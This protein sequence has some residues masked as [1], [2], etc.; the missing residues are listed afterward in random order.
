MN[1]NIWKRFRAGSPQEFPHV[2]AEN[3]AILGASGDP[4]TMPPAPTHTRSR[5][6]A[7]ASGVLML[8]ALASCGGH[9]Y[10][11][12]PDV[13]GVTKASLDSGLLDEVAVLPQP[14]V[15]VDR[16]AADFGATVK[17]GS[18]S[19]CVRFLP[20]TGE[21]PAHLASRLMGDSRVVVAEQNAIIETAEARQE[22]YASDDGNGSLESTVEQ[23]ALEAIGLSA[24]HDVSSGRGIRVAIID[25]GID[26]THPLF[27]GRIVGG[28]DYVTYDYDPTDVADGIDSDGDGQIDEAWG[29]GTHVAG[30]VAI[31]AP[32]AQ[33][34][35]ARVLDSDGR[36]DVAAV[37][38]GLRW[39]IDHGARVINMSLGMLHPSL[40][41]ETLL[42][43][44]Q[45]NGV[46][47]VCSAG[48]WGAE[49]PQEYPAVS[50]NVIAVAATDAYA[51]PAP[52]TSYGD[53][54]TLGAPGVAVRSAY[55]G[56]GW[57][58]W[59]GT[60]MS[61]PFVSGAAALLLSRHPEWNGAQVFARLGATATPGAHRV[62]WSPK[63]ENGAGCAPA[64][65][66]P[67]A[68][69]W[70]LA[71]G[72]SRGSSAPQLPAEHTTTMPSASACSSRFWIASLFF[73]MPRERLSTFA[74]CSIAQRMPVATAAIPP[75]PS[76]SSTRTGMMRA[77][78]AVR[79]TMPAT[80]VPWPKASSIRPSPSLSMPSPTSV[81]T[82]SLPT[83]S[84]PG[85][86]RFRRAWCSGSTPV[87]S[88]ATVTPRPS[89]TASAWSRWIAS[90]A[91]CSSQA[92]WEPKPSSEA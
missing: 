92:C 71:P 75:R 10:T 54:V 15:D 81:G 27:Q 86:S 43:Q 61:T 39:S 45:A 8:L 13:H 16:L 2:R 32:A 21:T 11:T 62:S 18:N 6:L 79:A 69:A 4:S 80:W 46:V 1:A 76:A 68:T 63:D 34:L 67:I 5:I 44:A 47:V 3:P 66:A 88:T 29:H 89:L 65:V 60:S 19:V 56:G 38:A 26:R 30:L 22:S 24:A 37:T 35:I 51:H 33:L 14:G 77:P 83:K 12:G 73:S 23:P 82:A 36:G 50:P 48:N 74:P 78:G 55:P 59:S 72:Y 20:Q 57:R 25:T 41:I 49:D 70:L 31:T 84:Q 87:S 42:T 40:C 90:V 85:T 52:F 7:L 9:E 53:F 58:L 17:P 91:G 64:S 28:V